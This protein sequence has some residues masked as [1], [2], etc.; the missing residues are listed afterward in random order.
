MKLTLAAALAHM[1]PA[2]QS[3]PRFVD[4][5]ITLTPDGVATAYNGQLAARALFDPGIGKGGAPLAAPVV[6]SSERLSK[7]WTDGATLA[8]DGDFL[9][10]RKRGAKY[11]IQQLSADM[12]ETPEIAPPE[13]PLTLPQVHAIQLASQ[14]ASRNAIH[15]WACGVIIDH[16]GAAATN[17]QTLVRVACPFDYQ[18]TLP[19]WA[20]DAL[21]KDA[22]AWFGWNDHS[23]AF[24]YDNGVSLMSA[25]LAAEAPPT[26]LHLLAGL[27][28]AREPVTGAALALAEAAR[29]GGRLCRLVPGAVTVEGAGGELASVEAG[30]PEGTFAMVMETAELVLAHATHLDFSEAPDRLIFSSDQEPRLFGLAAGMK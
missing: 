12:V 13:A 9:V 11:V 22:P 24:H 21:R 20:V 18:L 28:G 15:P 14:F 17:N 19:V 30:I 29:I 3:T 25:R 1:A 2:L 10:L 27:R 8:V 7:I 5:P 4:V 6:V 16:T 26:L 23:F